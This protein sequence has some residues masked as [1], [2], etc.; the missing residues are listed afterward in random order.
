MFITSNRI[1][2]QYFDVRK[3]NEHLQGSYVVDDTTGE[4]IP[5]KYI[6]REMIP[7]K[8]QLIQ[9]F[10]RE[11]IPKENLKLIE[12]TPIDFKNGIF[13]KHV[14][15]VKVPQP[16]ISYVNL[17]GKL[18]ATYDKPFKQR[19]KMFFSMINT[20]MFLNK[21][22]SDNELKSYL[23]FWIE[24]LHTPENEL[25]RTFKMLE[26]EIERL[27]NGGKNKSIIRHKV[28]VTNPAY[29]WKKGER[30]RFT[31]QLKSEIIN[32]E[33]MELVDKVVEP[34]IKEN[35]KITYQI[36]ADEIKK[37]SVKYVKI[38]KSTVLRQFK[39]SNKKVAS[40]YSYINTSDATKN[41]TFLKELDLIVEALKNKNLKITYQNLLLEYN[42]TYDKNYCLKTIKEKCSR[43][44]TKKFKDYNK[45]IKNTTV[46]PQHTSTELCNK[47]SDLQCLIN[48][49]GLD[50]AQ[51]IHNEYNNLK[52]EYY[53]KTLTA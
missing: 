41:V 19:I 35:K 43:G 17:N 16:W 31:N 9:N 15:V 32:A 46:F 39:K 51:K 11:I 13:E 48:V 29:K 42:V 6:Q 22:I 14:D 18:V 26:K 49:Y 8:I 37:T 28:V 34:L 21:D 4:I 1:L 53:N 20:L 44:F 30:K 33:F 10:C 36:I 2:L 27:K 38:N 50:A 23:L 47:D 12:E 7:I 45:K 24:Y 40:Q 5:V 3:N 52:A 25:E